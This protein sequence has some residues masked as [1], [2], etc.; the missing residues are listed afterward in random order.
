MV[1][2]SRLQ[3]S[4]MIERYG[5]ARIRWGG[6]GGDRATQLIVTIK[7]PLLSPLMVNRTMTAQLLKRLKDLWVSRRGDRKF[8]SRAD[9]PFED[10]SPWLG[11]IQ[12]VDV[13][14][15]EV[16]GDRYRFRLVGT[17]IV[18]FDGQDIT[19]MTAT[20]AFPGE[21]AWVTA[22]YDAAVDAEEPVHSQ[23]PHTIEN[24][25][26]IRGVQVLI[27]RLI[28]P[29]STDGKTVDMLVVYMDLIDLTT[30]GR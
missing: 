24:G 8:P 3:T 16:G 17:R 23:V 27:D 7:H 21:T 20:E 11:K 2:D 13:V 25:E 10:L 28:M 4:E 15:G 5:P 26:V 29:L 6:G 12:L 19:G 22:A 14:P 9:F 30:T 18:E 1:F